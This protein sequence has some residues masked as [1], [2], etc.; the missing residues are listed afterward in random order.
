MASSFLVTTA[1]VAF[2]LVI[3]SAEAA[4]PSTARREF[5][6]IMFFIGRTQGPG[7]LDTVLA[8]P[9]MVKVDSLGSVQGDLLVLR[10]SI[11]KGSEPA[12]IRQ[13]TMRRVAPSRYAGTF[14]DANG[15][16]L[17]IVDGSRAKISYSMK[18]G[19]SVRQVLDVQPDGRTMLNVLKVRK[20]GV[21][22]ATLRETIRR[23]K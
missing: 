6:P 15:P 12:N 11:Q 10:Q 19:L 5:N 2:I 17:I 13:W 1:A 7:T 16:V 9:V 22:V 3:G 4:A 20:L 18:G 8:K 21:R 23:V 14:T